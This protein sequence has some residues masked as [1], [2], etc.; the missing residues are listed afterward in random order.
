M[1]AK[2]GGPRKTANTDKLKKYEQI[3]IP[4]ARAGE[5]RQTYISVNGKGMYVPKGKT[6]TVPRY[7]ADQIRHTMRLEK[8]YEEDVAKSQEKEDSPALR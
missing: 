5:E 7:V 2:T 4:A 6:V 8:R 1:A 3:Y